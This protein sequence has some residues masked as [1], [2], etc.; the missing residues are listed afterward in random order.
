MIDLHTHT[1]KSD[2][3][4]SPRELIAAAKALGLK[5]VAVTD[6]DTI[7]GLAEAGEAAQEQ[8]ILLVPGIELEVFFPS[9]GEFHLLG[10]GLK[11]VNGAFESALKTLHER[12]AAR[13]TRI[14]AKMREHGL[15]VNQEEVEALAGGKIVSR[16]HFARYLVNRGFVKTIEKAFFLYLGKGKPFY[17]ERESLRI[18]EAIS[19][20]HTA[21][22]KAVLAHPL[23]LYLSW[24]KFEPQLALWKEM[25]LDGMEVYHSNASASDCTRLLKLAN[26]HKLLV[27]A[28]SDFH[29]ASRPDRHLGKSAC[30]K[31]ID[32]V[33]L[34]PF[35]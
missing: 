3:T 1:N 6:H 23:S 20:V 35:L 14:L 18:E 9:P 28:G 16:L 12:R 4:L 10:L 8:G 11:T 25:G 17:E 31:P 19:L 13:N 26:A 21:G 34:E 15:T 27:S 30:K 7:D 29:G 32:D 2:G 33:F 22:G 5:A 24:G